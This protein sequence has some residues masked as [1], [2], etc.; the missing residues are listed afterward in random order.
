M[1]PA[2]R[3]VCSHSKKMS[4]VK[5]SSTDPEVVT[6]PKMP[7]KF[8]Y[9]EAL[10]FTDSFYRL[11]NREVHHC[12]TTKMKQKLDIKQFLT[13]KY[14]A[15]SKTTFC[16][17]PCECKLSEYKWCFIFVWWQKNIL[18]RADSREK[19]FIL[20]V[21]NDYNLSLYK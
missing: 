15:A 20:T 14:Q 9:T 7:E 13:E 21:L 3:R 4:E 1:L 8:K 5:H 2:H 16:N 6:A 17:F 11:C 19:Y 18:R 12:I 10:V